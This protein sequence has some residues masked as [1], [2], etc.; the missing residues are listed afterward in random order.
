VDDLH[1]LCIVTG[2]V[3]IFA[4]TKNVIPGGLVVSAAYNAA[5][6]EGNV[7]IPEN[8]RKADNRFHEAVLEVQWS[9]QGKNDVLIKVEDLMDMVFLM[10]KVVQSS[11]ID[12]EVEKPSKKGSRGKK[13]DVAPMSDED[14]LAALDSLVIGS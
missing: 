13:D 12:H 14:L 1:C 5:V 11:A 7:L 4:G 3:G 9:N 8:I 2:V 6:D 10:A